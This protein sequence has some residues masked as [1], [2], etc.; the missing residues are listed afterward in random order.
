ME[1]PHQTFCL[2]PIGYSATRSRSAAPT[3]R[4]TR[5][6][7]GHLRRS[8]TSLRAVSIDIA[9]HREGRAGSRVINMRATADPNIG[10]VGGT[11]ANASKRQE[12]ITT[13]SLLAR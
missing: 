13:P 7:T 2:S 3:G 12:K 5:A 10:T 4:A 1:R 6:L 11:R 8:Q 9:F